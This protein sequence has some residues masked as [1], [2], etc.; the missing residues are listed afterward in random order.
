M[1]APPVTRRS[2]NWLT[3]RTLTS[4]ALLGWWL[5]QMFQQLSP[6]APTTFNASAAI[7]QAANAVQEGNLANTA[8]VLSYAALGALHL[9]Y[10]LEAA[11]RRG[12][13]RVLV[14][15]LTLYLAWACLSVLWSVDQTLTVRRVGQLGLLIV[16][17]V[18]LGAGFY[19]R[20]PDG[21]RLLMT[22]VLVAGVTAMATLWLAVL[23]TGSID[24]LDPAFAA[25]SLGLGTIV[26]H[27]IAYSL[28][29]IVYMWR[30]RLV[31]V[32]IV[33][34]YLMAGVLALFAQKVRF[35]SAYS[36]L[37]VFVLLAARVN[38]VRAAPWLVGVGFAASTSLAIAS[39]QNLAPVGDTLWQFAS[40]GTTAGRNLEDLSGR[41][42]LWSELQHYVDDRPLLGYGF[43]AFWNPDNLR[44]VQKVISWAP[45]VAHNGF[46]D[47][48]L[49][50][51]Y[52]GAGLSV[53][54]WAIGLWIALA[55]AR[56]QLDDFAAVVAC[57]TALFLLL[58]W[59][60]SIMQL[61][62]RFPFY[63]SLVAL[64]TL[65]SRGSRFKMAKWPAKSGGRVS[66]QR[67]GRAATNSSTAVRAPVEK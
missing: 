19:G 57:W 6:S 61:Y 43:G 12:A 34:L 53:L 5:F 23:S 18:G 3:D 24:L 31:H 35:I 32:S 44:Q 1:R 14:L 38:L 30:Q 21:P 37:L 56:D 58:N 45:V 59:G 41:A 29:A 7:D 22:H 27:P 64:F 40:V 8:L 15:V 16:G 54:F 47:E 46:L 66:V 48:T 52:V 67:P 20:Y 28:F 63:V 9:R 11:R 51:G 26:A 39:T 17:S 25:K 4:A 50:T 65:A 13:V 10:T 2:R 55:R 36:G 33:G 62:F 49:A 42:E 60:D